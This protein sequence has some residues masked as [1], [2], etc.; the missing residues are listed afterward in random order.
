MAGKGLGRFHEG[1]RGQRVYQG[2]VQKARDFFGERAADR[3]KK[4][5]RNGYGRSTDQEEARTAQEN[6]RLNAER[7]TMIDYRRYRSIVSDLMKS[8]GCSDGGPKGMEKQA[9]EF[10]AEK[11]WDKFLIEEQPRIYPQKD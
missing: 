9:M 10:M 3:S 7:I 6:K 2:T 8:W 1:R 11:I 5:E 4:R